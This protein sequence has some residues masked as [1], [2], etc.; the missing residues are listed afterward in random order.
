VLR[1]ASYLL[2]E[3]LSLRDGIKCNH[4]NGCDKEEHHENGNPKGDVVEM[5][6]RDRPIPLSVNYMLVFGIYILGGISYERVH[7][8]YPFVLSC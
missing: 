8:T 6:T 1:A 7:I 5:T 2:P 4:N 3:K